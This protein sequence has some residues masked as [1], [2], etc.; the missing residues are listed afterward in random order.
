MLCTCFVPD[1]GT[2]VSA[3]PLTIY[4]RHA[5]DCPHEAKGRRWNRCDCPIWV[6]G[7]L[8]GEYVRE[9]LNLTVWGA[10]QE[11]VRGWEA[12]GQVGVVK[13][14]A[15]TIKEAVAKHVADAEARNLK[16][17]SI[18]KIR[19]VLERR[20][21]S[22]CAAQGYRMLRQ[23]DTDAIREFRNEFIKDY[24]A[25]SARK[26]LEYVRAFFRFCHQSGWIAANP[27]AV[28]KPPRAD[29]LPT[30]PLEQ[31]Q[32]EAMLKAADE[33]RIQGTF[34]KGN[35]KRIRAMILLLRYSGLRI[36]DAAV[37]ERSRLSGDKLFLYTQKT[38]TP[39]WIPLP[40]HT[41]KALKKS[42]T[43]NEKY[44]FWNGRS[45]ATSAV[46]IWERT[47]DTVFVKARI[48]DGTIHRF[49]DTFAVELLLKGVPIEHVSILLGHSSL[50]ITEKHYSPWVKARQEQLEAAVRKAW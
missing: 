15:P 7:S 20:F 22:Y 9:S 41:V 8:G 6:Q 37:L 13:N 34:G 32:V 48:Y 14:E 5:G 11:R 40:P 21:L 10:A 12:S 36:S 31:A 43:E 24:S 45:L 26:R 27:A 47:F 23:M 4:R 3:M 38:G 44:F 29:Q 16:P 42:P 46:K 39:V 33:F 19:D 1:C 18:K 35:R 2:I 30:M 50:K 28:I 25:N 17:E 49:R